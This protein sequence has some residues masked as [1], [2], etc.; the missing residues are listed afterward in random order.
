M[1]VPLTLRNTAIDGLDFFLLNNLYVKNE[2]NRSSSLAYLNIDF[3]Y[4]CQQ[5]VIWLRYNIL[6]LEFFLFSSDRTYYGM[7]DWI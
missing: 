7:N 2:H 6:S 3:T 5:K 4:K 1:A